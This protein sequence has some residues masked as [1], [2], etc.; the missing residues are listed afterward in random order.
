MTV[1]AFN[2]QSIRPHHRHEIL[3]KRKTKKKKRLPNKCAS[4][5]QS[6]RL[7]MWADRYALVSVCTICDTMDAAV[8]AEWFFL[9]ILLVFYFC[10]FLRTFLQIVLSDRCLCSSFER[11]KAFIRLVNDKSERFLMEW[12]AHGGMVNWAMMFDSAESNVRRQKLIKFTLENSCDTFC[13]FYRRANQ[14][15]VAAFEFL[16]GPAKLRPLPF[17]STNI[18]A[19]T[20][21]AVQ[22][23]QYQLRCL[24][25]ANQ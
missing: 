13:A 20:C 21:A 22:L 14:V 25:R 11:I 8:S 7:C 17:F 9:M 19:N 3:T 6:D 23:S 10:F 15:F 2:K 12:I 5:K 24:I 18:T 4:L 16:F 1:N